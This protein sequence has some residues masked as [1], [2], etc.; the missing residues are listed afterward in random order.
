MRWND[1]FYKTSYTDA[2]IRGFLQE[3][4]CS[5]FSSK[6]KILLLLFMKV[7]KLFT[8][9]KIIFESVLGVFDKV[10]WEILFVIFKNMNGCEI[11]IG[12]QI[13]FYFFGIWQLWW[14]VI[15]I[16]L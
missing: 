3:G 12:Y 9:V 4:C 13:G 10:I 6:L 1:I 16:V 5:F 2:L 7:L 11:E 8:A 14:K 15:T